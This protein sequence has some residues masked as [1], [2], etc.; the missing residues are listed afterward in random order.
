MKCQGNYTGELPTLNVVKEGKIHRIYFNYEEAPS[1]TEDEGEE[2]SLPSFVCDLIEIDEL[3]YPSIVSAIV[4]DRY[5]Q[6]DVE[7]IISNYQLCKD[8]KAG[9]DRCIRYE[10]DYNAYQDYRAMAKQVANQIINL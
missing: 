3:T 7:A 10:E 8:G 6:N 2:N 9:E 4:R 1:I 5:S